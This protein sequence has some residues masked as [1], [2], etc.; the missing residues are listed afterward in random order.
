MQFTTCNPITIF[1]HF[2]NISGIFLNLSSAL[3]TL[4]AIQISIAP[5]NWFPQFEI[6]I[7]LK[8]SMP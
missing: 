6:K 3:R 2:Y 4:L 8:P 1:E 7:Y 5:A